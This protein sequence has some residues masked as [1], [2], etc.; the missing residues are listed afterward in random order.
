MRK[1]VD[2]LYKR[3]EKHFSLAAEQ[4]GGV[5]EEGSALQDV[6]VACQDELLKETENFQRLMAQCYES[7]GVTL[8]YTLPEVE[9]YFKAARRSR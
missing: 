7:T 1:Y 8:E 9:Q 3:V 2:A 6:W 4:P 5:A